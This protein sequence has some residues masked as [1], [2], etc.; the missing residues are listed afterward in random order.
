MSKAVVGQWQSGAGYDQPTYTTER[1]YA[2]SKSVKL[3]ARPN[4]YN[5]SVNQNGSFPVIYMD[6]W[7][8]VDLLD[9]VSRNWKPWRVYG[10]NDKLQV[11]GV[12]MC[13]GNGLSFLNEQREVGYWWGEGGSF[14]NGQWQHFQVMMKASSAPN[15]ADGAIKQYIN[16]KLVSDHKGLVTR[17]TSAHW[18]QIRIGHYWATEAVDACTSN[19]GANIYLDNV[20]IDTSWAHIEL[21]NA[22]TYSASTKR[23]IQIPTR[24]SSN[25]ITFT[26]NASSFPSGSTA[27]LYV[28]DANGE[29]NANGF[30]VVIGAGSAEKVPAPPANVSVQ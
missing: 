30:P 4:A 21:G 28:T 3:A 6:W 7:V 8:R 15:V 17:T 23:E 29:V 9:N 20:Y 5:L 16:G 19:S 2:G 26:V 12:V 27:Y 13:N 22:S 11:N 24:W 25:S 18:D 1:A 14:S 10:A